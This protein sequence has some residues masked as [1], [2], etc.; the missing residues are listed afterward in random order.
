MDDSEVNTYL[1]FYNAKLK[2]W[3]YLKENVGDF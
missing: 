3:P 2:T 1:E